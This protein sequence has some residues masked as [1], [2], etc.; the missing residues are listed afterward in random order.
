MR[1]FAFS[2]SLRTGSWNTKLLKLAVTLLESKGV[3]VDVWDFRAA[4]VPPYDP[5]TSDTNYPPQLSDAKARIRAAQGVLL[6]SPEYNHSIPGVVKNLFDFL[7]RP[8]KDNP[9]KGKLFAQL[10]AT[11]GGFGT[12]HAQVQLRHLFDTLGGW[13]IPGQVM[14][15]SAPTAFDETGQLK[16]E[17]RRQE[18]ATF[19]E[20]FAATLKTHGA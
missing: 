14:I 20:R 9:F 1:V 3:E 12:V 10:G 17:N 13:S 2:G 7:S 15:S 19:I 16:D 4:Q 8:P 5:D 18:L 11:P 6:C